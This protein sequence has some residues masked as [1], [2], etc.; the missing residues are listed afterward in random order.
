M[1]FFISLYNALEG[2]CGLIIQATEF[3]EKR[4][5]DGVLKGKKGYSEI[6][7]RV[8]KVFLKVPKP[9]KEDVEDICRANG[10]YNDEFIQTIYNQ[11]DGDL[12][13]V[14]TKVKAFLKLA[15]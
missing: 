4:I 7:S 14:K 11:A 10:L 1:Y 13:S 5:D 3:L 8:G 15:S 2:K 9:S 12:R 6:Y